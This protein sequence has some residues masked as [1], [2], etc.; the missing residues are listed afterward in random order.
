MTDA[1][2]TDEQLRE[3]LTTVARLDERGTDCPPADRLV[4]SARGEL[5][6]PADRPV[7]LH[8][9]RCTACA[10]A[11]R[12][13]REV[14]STADGALT[15]S[16]VGTPIRS[17]WVRWAAAAVLMLAV[18]ALGVLF[19]GPERETAPVLRAPEG[20]ALR[21]LLDERQPLP[22]DRFVLRWR[23]GPE[24][25]FYDLRVMSSDLETLA[26]IEGL[27]RSEFHVPE[28]TL[29]TLASG[30]R[31]LWQVSALLPTGQRVESET[32]FAEIE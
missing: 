15:E 18:V 14:A 32:F 2:F 27:D 6:P 10:A 24:G 8:I 16:T 9:A 11:W 4:S 25:T 3:G 19:V 21:S 22:R 26:R 7:V 17:V 12:I 23:P 13:A 29:A 1:S 5:D 20:P 30:S 31:V 28:E